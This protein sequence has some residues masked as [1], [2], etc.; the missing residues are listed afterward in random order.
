MWYNSTPICWCYC[1]AVEQ[2]DSVTWRSAGPGL[3]SSLAQ[4]HCQADSTS[5]DADPRAPGGRA[6][7]IIANA[8]VALWPRLG[9]R[10][11]SPGGPGSHCQCSAGPGPVVS[12]TQSLL[13]LEGSET[14]SRTVHW[15]G[16]GLVGRHLDSEA[17]ENRNFDILISRYRS[18]KLQYRRSENWLRCRG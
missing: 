1:S 10:V 12:V 15:P 16:D 17:N 4:T 7:L 6:S 5:R 11:G 18:C 13:R 2:P 3:R 9:V 14:F 8:S